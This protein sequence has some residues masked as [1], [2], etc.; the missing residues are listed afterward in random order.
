MAQ[1][2]DT[3]I[4]ESPVHS[5]CINAAWWSHISGVI[6]QL[7]YRDYW[8]GTESDVDAAVQA[9]Y[10]LLNVGEPNLECEASVYPNHASMWHDESTVLTGGALVTFSPATAP[11]AKTDHYYNV[12][13]YQSTFANGDSFYQPFLLAAGTYNFGV[14]G[15]FNNVHGML[16][17]YLDEALIV[18]SQ[19]WY[20]GS[21][22][23]N[24]IF[25]N[26]VNVPTS[27]AHMLKGVVNGKN[28]AAL[29]YAMSLTKYWFEVVP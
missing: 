7:T 12:A 6:A 13:A 23:Q 11:I 18:T 27:G 8:S 4:F 25:T 5:I 29:A 19:D 28:A 22:V 14:L 20:S 17:W 10:E 1:P 21:V 3:G 24:R 9:I 15:L 16:D 26:V 2:P